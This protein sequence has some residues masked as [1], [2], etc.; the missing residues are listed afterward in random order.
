MRYHQITREERY[1]LATLRKQ[2]PRPSA[3]TMAA[4]LGRHRSTISREFRRN[5]KPYDGAYRP[6]VAQERANGRRSRSRR[7]TRFTVADWKLIHWLLGQLLSPEQI[8]GRLREEGLLEISH[9]TIYQ[10]IWRDKRRGGHL[11]LFLRQRLRYRKRY[12]RYEK[13]GRVEGKRHISERPAVVEQRNE[14]GHWEMDTVLGT[15]D[16]HCVVSLV[17]RA[18]GTLL[19]GKA[20]SRKAAHVTAKLIELIEAH[21]GLFKTIT[22]DNGTEFHSYREVEA[23]T[24]VTIYFATPYHSWERGTN[25]NTNGLIRQYLPKRTS[26]KAITQARCNAIAAALN[27]RPRKRYRFRTPLEQLQKEFTIGFDPRYASPSVGVAVQTGT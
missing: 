9:E 14:I 7:N 3:A 21:P 26:M 20:R 27:N 13:R 11:W 2:T 18:T 16:H 12:G 23:A 8:S 17:E 24:G 5:C 22:A 4:L 6:S 1:T 15:G 10:H 19:L 25:E